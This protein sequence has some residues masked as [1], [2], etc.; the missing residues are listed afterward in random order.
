V[1]LTMAWVSDANGWIFS[2]FHKQYNFEVRYG[3]KSWWCNF[4]LGIETRT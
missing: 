2:W 4:N 1:L 3:Q